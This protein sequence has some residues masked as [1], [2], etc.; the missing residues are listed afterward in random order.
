MISLL[1]L[2]N[3]VS[4]TVS[5]LGSVST[6]MGNIVKLFKTIQHSFLFQADI[7]KTQMSSKSAGNKNVLRVLVEEREKLLN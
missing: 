7:M 2:I 5:C 6:Q 4:F 3:S 1:T